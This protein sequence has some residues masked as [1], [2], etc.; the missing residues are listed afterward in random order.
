MASRNGLSIRSS[1]AVPPAAR[2][3]PTSSIE[4][5]AAATPRR[6]RG[7]G[8]TGSILNRADLGRTLGVPASTLERYL[9]T[10]RTLY[11]VPFGPHLTAAPVHALW[12]GP[13]G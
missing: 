9:A 5:S 8:R 4:F 13:R 1:P 6:S 12:G 2:G 10:L 7:P 11:L 3:A